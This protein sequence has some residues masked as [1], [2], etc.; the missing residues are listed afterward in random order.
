MSERERAR[1]PLRWDA[2]VRADGV[3]IEQA[4]ARNNSWYLVVPAGEGFEA[5]YASQSANALIRLESSADAAKA[6]AEDHAD[7]YDTRA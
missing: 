1:E 3:R 7:R 2:L 5:R 4:R 6:A